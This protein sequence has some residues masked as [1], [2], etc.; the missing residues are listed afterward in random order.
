M[1]D[2]NTMADIVR[3]HGA[4]LPDKIAL[5]QAGRDSVTW[6]QLLER[7]ARIAQA[8]ADAGVGAGDRVAFLDKNSI[9]H[10]EVFFGAAMLNAVCVDVNWRLAAP[11]VEFI[12][13]DAEAKVLVVGPDFV[14][15]LDAIVDQL[16]KVT[17]SS[18]S[19]VT[20]RTRTTT[21]GWPAPAD[22]PGAQAAADDV[23]FQ[24]YSSGT[25]GRPKGVMLSND[26]FFALLPLAKDMWGIRRDSVNLVAMPLFHIGGGGWAVAGMYEGATSVI[27]RDLDPAALIRLI[28]RARI[29]H[30]FLVPAVLQFMLMVPGVDDADFSSLADDRLRRLADQRGGAGQVRRARSGA[31]SGRPTA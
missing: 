1:S 6:A 11:E 27:V 31:S 18:S 15:V 16:P 14:P 22:D 20:R 29:T 24:L 26:N 8:L 4:G 19:A 21:S 23:A 7:S 17:K 28:E 10:F 12:V 9:E 30:A 5:V 25:T 13:N 2:I 3:V